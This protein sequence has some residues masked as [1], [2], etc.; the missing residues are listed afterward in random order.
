MCI[1]L[2]IKFYENICSLRPYDLQKSLILKLLYH[3]VLLAVA[4]SQVISTSIA[5]GLHRLTYLL[6][7]EFPIVFYCLQT[8]LENIEPSFYV[9]PMISEQPR[10][11]I[12]IMT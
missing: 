5:T 12:K 8:S 10:H 1:S 7:V 11:T 4:S 9:L 6:K 3:W 2:F